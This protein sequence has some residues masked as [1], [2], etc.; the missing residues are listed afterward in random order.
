MHRCNGSGQEKYIWARSARFKGEGKIGHNGAL[1]VDTGKYTGRSP[2]DKYF[3]VESSSKDNLWWGEV[4]QEISEDIFDELY[5]KVISYYNSKLEKDKSYIFDGFG[6]DHPDFS[7]PLRVIASCPWQAYFC[8][9][10]FIR[11]SQNQLNEFILSVKSN[12]KSKVTFEDGRNA[13]ILANAAYE[14]HNNKKVV[15][16]DF[17]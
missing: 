6:G 3:V 1:M 16:I 10:M 13:L 5:D 17:S 15:S 4:N 11:P 7:L 14:S 8:N 2:K 12:S 9:N